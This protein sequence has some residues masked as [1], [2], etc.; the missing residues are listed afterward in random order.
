MAV[1]FRAG[2]R[3]PSGSVASRRLTFIGTATLLIASSVVPRPSAQQT[4]VFRGTTDLVAV[5]VHVVTSSGEPVLGLTAD[6]FEVLV[7]GRRRRLIT[8][9]FVQGPRTDAGST[10]AVPRAVDRPA[11]APAAQDGRT[12][13]LAL[14]VVGLSPEAV[15]DVIGAAR[16]FVERL[17][18]ADRVGVFIHPVGAGLDPT[19]RIIGPSLT[20]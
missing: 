2:R 10:A 8:A 4:S 3:R 9:N 11:A 16:R 6:K 15:R 19:K 5:D 17:Q 20:R 18:P 1:P 13:I 7:N 14:D 12:F